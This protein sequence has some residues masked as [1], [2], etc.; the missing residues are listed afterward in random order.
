MILL[1]DQT[2]TNIFHQY[3]VSAIPDFKTIAQKGHNIDQLPLSECWT[4]S[5]WFA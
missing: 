4:D 1:Q 3:D 5:T 2:F